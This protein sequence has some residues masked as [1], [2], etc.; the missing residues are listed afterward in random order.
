MYRKKYPMIYT[1]GSHLIAE[2][3]DEL[4]SYADKIGLNRY[5]LQLSG[6]N[7]H[8]HF[9]ICGKVKERILADINVK[10]VSAKEIVKICKL[11]FRPPQTDSEVKEWEERNGK[12]IDDIK[13]SESDYERMMRNIFKRSGVK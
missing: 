13:P 3:L 6:R 9:D 12:S 4:C 10:K 7:L 5:W 8:P 1:D 2:S 11:S